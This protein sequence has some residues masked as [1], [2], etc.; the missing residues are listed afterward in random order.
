MSL[1]SIRTKISQLCTHIPHWK[2]LWR[3]QFKV[4][5]TLQRAYGINPSVVISLLSSGISVAAKNNDRLCLKTRSCKRSFD[6]PSRVLF[7]KTAAI[8]LSETFVNWIVF[9]IALSFGSSFLA[10]CTV[11]FQ[12]VVQSK[13]TQLLRQLA[14][15][16]HGSWNG[17]VLASSQTFEIYRR[18]R[19][20]QLQPRDFSGLPHATCALSSRPN[21]FH[22]VTS[23][24][25]S[26]SVTI[27]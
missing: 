11:V 1:H 12:N 25:Y 14:F 15:L 9:K 18:S 16:E 13:T 8:N 19:F 4:R 3:C 23:A 2:R 10:S 20:E 6:E 26:C 5:R 22:D 7:P 17:M 24:L 21:V 27:L